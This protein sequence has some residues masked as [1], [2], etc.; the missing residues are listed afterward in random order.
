MPPGDG[1]NYQQRPQPPG[2]P[3]HNYGEQFSGQPLP[4]AAVWPQQQAPSRK[5]RTAL[6]T[7]TGLAIVLVIAITAGVTLLLARGND[8]QPSN[9]PL[10]TDVAST[11]DAG[12][13]GVVTNDPTCKSL[14]EIS[15]VLAGVQANGWSAQRKTLGPVNEWTDEQRAFIEPV[16]TAVENASNQMLGLAGQTPH[17]VMRELYEQYAAYG[18]A[19]VESLPRYVP[20]DD[21]LAGANVSI[22]NAL[23]GICTSIDRGSVSRALTLTTVDSPSAA[24]ENASGDDPK[25]FLTT[26]GAECGAWTDVNDRFLAGTNAWASLDTDVPAA[27]WS[28]EQRS[29]QLAAL[30]TFATFADD[31]EAVGRKSGNPVFEDF[32]VLA[33]EYARAYVTTGDDY[34]SADSWL[35]YTVLRL[36]N[37]LSAACRFAAS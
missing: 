15:R 37:T 26:P 19:Y 13:V 16:S 33:A 20:S 28:P 18:R 27:Q 10:P 36:I 8:P 21:A 12:A 6:W 11:A 31:A 32:A 3:E 9:P 7:L 5:R 22:G 30:P 4:T 29:V 25:M 2:T 35:S 24:T 1:W 17:R 34:T 14:T 23:V